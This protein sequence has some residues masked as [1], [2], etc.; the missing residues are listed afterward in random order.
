MPSFVFARG[1][2]WGGRQLRLVWVPR[3]FDLCFTAVPGEDISV[4]S[5]R[6]LIS[7]VLTQAQLADS[8]LWDFC[9]KSCQDPR[10]IN[11]WRR[12][13]AGYLQIFSWFA[14][15][16]HKE[17]FCLM[18]GL[19]IWKAK[20]NSADTVPKSCP[21]GL[22]QGQIGFWPFRRKD[23]I[24]SWANSWK[25]CV[26]CLLRSRFILLLLEQIDC[27]LVLLCF[28]RGQNLCKQSGQMKSTVSHS[29]NILVWFLVWSVLQHQRPWLECI[30]AETRL[31]STV[32]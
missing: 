12:F 14:Y 25:V 32:I 21:N 10:Q 9:K 23:M 26:S 13:R 22:A 24:P 18:F 1:W 30:C 27:N 20:N 4:G 17:G 6:H 3:P 28:G 2:R 19:M 31:F 8:T 5:C 29:E 7:T 11:R 16:M 15:F